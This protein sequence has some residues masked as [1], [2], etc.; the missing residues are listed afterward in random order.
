ML[1]SLQVSR[2][3]PPVQRLAGQL[4]SIVAR[5][6]YLSAIPHPNRQFSKHF[7]CILLLY[8]WLPREIFQQ[9]ITRPISTAQA[10]R[11]TEQKHL[12]SCCCWLTSSWPTL[13]VKPWGSAAVA[14]DR[15]GIRNEQ[16][17]HK[18][19][20]WPQTYRHLKLCWQK[21]YASASGNLHYFLFPSRESYEGVGYR[22][23]LS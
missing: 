19:M 13:Q 7:K 20:A 4:I 9:S 10:V 11:R 15:A 6:N 3:H 5:S 2:I 14:G 21:V 22:P 12:V 23:A 16:T 8:R 1:L 17:H 18:H